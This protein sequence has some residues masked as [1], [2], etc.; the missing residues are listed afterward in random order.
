[1]DVHRASISVAVRDDVGKPAMECVIETKA[2]TL[3]DFLAACVE[4]YVRLS[5]IRLAKSWS[6][7][8]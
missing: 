5:V 7:C 2:A 1:M 8:C 3:L 4:P 6:Y